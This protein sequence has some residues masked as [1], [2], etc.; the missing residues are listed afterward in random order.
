MSTVIG[1]KRATSP[2]GVQ[3]KK[4]V[5]KA[6]T[7]DG[8]IPALSHEDEAKSGISAFVLI[9][10]NAALD[11]IK[12]YTDAG[13]NDIVTFVNYRLVS[14]LSSNCVNNNLFIGLVMDESR[15]TLHVQIER[16][17]KHAKISKITVVSGETSN[18]FNRLVTQFGFKITPN[19]EC[20][21]VFELDENHP[22][23]AMIAPMNFR[24]PMVPSF[25][26]GPTSQSISA[27][28]RHMGAMLPTNVA[29]IAP[30]SITARTLK[31]PADDDGRAYL[32]GIVDDM[33]SIHF[34]M[35]AES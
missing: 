2:E 5:Q 23:L 15:G 20:H 7:I 29:Q 1:T 9:V 26:F 21:R 13:L 35:S 8:S 6:S 24:E 31:C 34:D 27:S 30:I 17:K 4:A 33:I 19:K 25:T 14:L 28:L 32:S 12:E 10:L 22:Y 11:A 3:R 18:H 16:S